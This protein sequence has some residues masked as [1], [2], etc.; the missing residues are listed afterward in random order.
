IDAL[1]E[2]YLFIRTE[3][4]PVPGIVLFSHSTLRLC[5]AGGVM[6]KE[7]VEIFQA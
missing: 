3:L 2:T 5:C 6:S 1:P 7:G 4:T